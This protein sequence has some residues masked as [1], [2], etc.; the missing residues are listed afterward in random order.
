VH[1][2][3]INT[4]C[5]S[6]SGLK[7]RLSTSHGTVSTRSA[8]EDAPPPVQPISLRYLNGKDGKEYDKDKDKARKIERKGERS[9]KEFDRKANVAKSMVQNGGVQTKT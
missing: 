5:S 7:T 4:F 6:P 3:F 9:S 1:G 2:G 8:T